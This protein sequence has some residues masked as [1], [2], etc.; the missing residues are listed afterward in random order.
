MIEYNINI[1]LHD[2]QLR[3]VKLDA[4]Q[5]QSDFS[6][7]AEAYRYFESQM[8]ESITQSFEAH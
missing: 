3:E 4:E 5:Y 6:S 7:Y 8:L 1:S 2:E